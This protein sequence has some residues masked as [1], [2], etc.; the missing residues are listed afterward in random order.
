[1]ATIRWSP[2]LFAALGAGFQGDATVR[3]GVHLRW[4]LDPRMGLPTAP[5]D[6]G[7][8]IAFSRTKEGSIVRVDLFKPS[9]P[10]PVRSNKTV[11]CRPA[12]A[13]SIET[14]AD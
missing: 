11:S 12:P 14:A 3:D 13:W 5:R 2:R 6:K 1:M 8:E 10:Y 4:T 9:A 7:F